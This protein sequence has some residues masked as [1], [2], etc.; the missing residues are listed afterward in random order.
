MKLEYFMFEAE[1]W[2][3]FP[4][5]E[6]FGLDCYCFSIGC[7]TCTSAVALWWMPMSGEADGFIDVVDSSCF[8]H[9]V[10]CRNFRQCWFYS[11]DIRCCCGG[12]Y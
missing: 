7:Q 4:F 9:D 5:R 6:H 3:S 2:T 11:P 12:W 10:D 1:S 8:K